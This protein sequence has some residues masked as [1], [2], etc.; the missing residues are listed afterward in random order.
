MGTSSSNG[1]PSGKS[2]LLPTYY[3]PGPLPSQDQ[4]ATD[5]GSPTDGNDGTGQPDPGVQ[6]PGQT[7]LPQVPLLSGIGVVLNG[8]SRALLRKLLGRALGRPQKPMSVH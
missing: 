5:P 3:D 7:I 8:H 4:Q 6:Q 1:G 2:S